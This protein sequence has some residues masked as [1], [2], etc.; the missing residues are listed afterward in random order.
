[1]TRQTSPQTPHSFIGD[2][3]DVNPPECISKST[4]VL[5]PQFGHF[6][7]TPPVAESYPSL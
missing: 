2:S 3:S 5:S 7:F 6:M 4:D 1:L